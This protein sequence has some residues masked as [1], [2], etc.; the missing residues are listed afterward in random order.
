MCW[1]GCGTST[2]PYDLLFDL[3]WTTTRSTAGVNIVSPSGEVSIYNKP[4][5]EQF[6]MLRQWIIDGIIPSYALNYDTPKAMEK[7]L[8]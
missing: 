7:W 2:F 4:A 8:K 6:T 3:N 5:V 1:N